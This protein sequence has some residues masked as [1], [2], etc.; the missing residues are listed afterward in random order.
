MVILPHAWRRYRERTGFLA[1]DTFRG[2]PD[3]RRPLLIRQHQ[4][5]HDYLDV[6]TKRIRIEAKETNLGVDIKGDDTDLNS[7]G[8][9]SPKTR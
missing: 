5:M 1:T 9:N 7:K 6:L 8:P 3:N 4:A 2:L